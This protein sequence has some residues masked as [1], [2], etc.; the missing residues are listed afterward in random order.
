MATRTATELPSGIGRFGPRF[1]LLVA[2]L[3]GL[4]VF[5]LVAYSRQFTEG[6]SVT[7][8]RDLGPMG[9]VPWGIYI[10]FVVY[11]VGGS[12]AGISVAALIRVLNLEH[13][14]PVSRR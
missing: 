11:F 1:L 3:L 8:L 12:F 4:V 13:L 9:G 5:G 10:A 14:R 7:G 6:E 2:G